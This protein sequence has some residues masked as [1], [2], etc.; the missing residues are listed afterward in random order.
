MSFIIYWKIEMMIKKIKEWKV[1]RSWGGLAGSA[2][3][4]G[5][6]ASGLAFPGGKY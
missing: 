2:L 5:L 3:G 4:G 1:S 6:T